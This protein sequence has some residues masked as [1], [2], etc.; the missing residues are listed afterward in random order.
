MNER[1]RILIAIA[2]RIARYA[3]C[4]I[5]KQNTGGSS[6]SCSIPKEKK[7]NA[8]TSILRVSKVFASFFFD[9]KAR[10]WRDPIKGVSEIAHFLAIANSQRLQRLDLF[11]A[12]TCS[13]D[14][15]LDELTS[16]SVRYQLFRFQFNLHNVFFIAR[17]VY[18]F[19]QKNYFSF[20]LFISIFFSIFSHRV[21]KKKKKNVVG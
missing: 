20:H 18:F 12:R 8:P 21:L 15:R 3:R 11:L 14:L 7:N 9:A 5:G 13:E 17:S 4:S 1:T 6:V 10:L 2:R 19:I 16:T